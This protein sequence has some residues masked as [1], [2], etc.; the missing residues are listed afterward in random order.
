MTNRF[1]LTDLA[2][3]DLLT[4]D[5]AVIA[6]LRV[7][8][9]TRT[10]NKPIG[11]IAEHIVHIARGGSLEPNSTK[12]HDI[13]TPTG[14]RIQ[15]KAMG[16]RIAGANGKFSA[17]RSLDF[18]SAVFL[19]FDATTF[20]LVEAYETTADIIEKHAR[21]V[22]HINGRQPTLRQVR[23]LCD[24]VLDEMTTAYAAIDDQFPARS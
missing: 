2:V 8:G 10:N 20:N 5:A 9:L 4:L 12:S 24:D 21:L 15:V 6:E 1:P 3:R 16:A 22:P 18:D 23:N 11:D 14:K 7:R 19:V 13:T 17:F